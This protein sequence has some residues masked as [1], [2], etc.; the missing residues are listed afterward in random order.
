MAF[1]FKKTMIEGVLVVQPRVFPDAR[2]FFLESYR[3]E[4]FSAAGIE[5]EFVQDNHSFSQKDVIRG[6]HFQRAPRAQ[7]KLVRVARGAVYDVA[8]DIRPSS[9]TYGKWFGIELNEE[10]CSMLYI[11][12]G[13]AHGFATLRDDTVFL[14]K[15]TDIYSPEHDG[16]ILWNDPDIAVKWPVDNPILSDKDKVRPLLRDLNHN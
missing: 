6:L 10:N 11:A 9:P 1:E 16:G 15:C 8:V 12:P 7:G 4:E 3:K 2:G 13:L 14:Y 5:L